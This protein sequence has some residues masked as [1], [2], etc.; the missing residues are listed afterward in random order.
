[1]IVKL[2]FLTISGP[3]HDLDRMVDTYLSGYDFHLENALSQLKTKDQLRPF[4]GMDPYH[5]YLEKTR[6]LISKMRL[7]KE[8]KTSMMHS[9]NPLPTFEEIRASID[10]CQKKTFVLEDKIQNIKAELKEL[11]EKLSLLEPYLDLDYNLHKLHDLHFIKFKFGRFRTEDYDKFQKYVNDRLT[12]FFLPAHSD[13]HYI[14]GIAFAP[15]TSASQVEAIYTS[16]NFLPIE[17]PDEFD[18]TPKK[19]FDYLSK[20]KEGFEQEILCLQEEMKTS[21]LKEKEALYFYQNRLETLSNQ[22][23]IRRQAVVTQPKDDLEPRYIVCGW[24]SKKDTKHFLASIEKD[25]LIFCIVDEKEDEQIP[26]TKLCNPGIFKAYE[27]FVHMYGTPNYHEL[28]PT[29]L[30]AL[31]YSFIFGAMFGDV[32]QGLVLA[33]AG[34]LLYRIKHLQLGGIISLAG[35]FSTLFGFLYGSIFGFEDILK[36][37]WLSPMHAMMKLPIVGSVNIVFVYSICFGMILIILTLLINIILAIRHKLMGKALFSHHAIAG[38]IFYLTVLTGL[39]MIMMNQKIIGGAILLTIIIISL[40]VVVFKEQFSDLIQKKKPSLHGESAGMFGV[41]SFFELFEM[42][43]SYFSNTLSFV[44]IGAFAISHGAMMQVVMMLA[45]NENGN[46][47]W[48][49]VILGNLF[50]GG[51]E[52]LVVGIQVLR[53]E[54]YELF[55]HFYQGDGRPFKSFGKISTH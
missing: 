27:M 43:L 26:P 32:G 14:W 5:P 4:T 23:N 19:A 21:L 48:I 13:E 20:Q 47:N 15:V 8:E 53:L 10:E 44:R 52:A 41:I 33:I 17:I 1:M 46:L 37:L 3:K 25:D 45:A 31:T 6:Q 50:I 54:Y 9:P 18:S 12:T 29:I 7:S 2:D 42:L 36:P 24:M 55:S 39:G 51:M 40:I 49:V 22:F 11:K 34:Y 35:I 28:D 30:V 38:L 16:M